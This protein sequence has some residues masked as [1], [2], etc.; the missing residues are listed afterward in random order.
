MF[1]VKIESHIPP[2]SSPKPTNEKIYPISDLQVGDSF[3][4]PPDM[5]N[6]ARAAVSQY[7][8][9]HRKQGWD[10]RTSSNPYNGC[11]IWRTA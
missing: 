5:A 7:K 10:Y 9:N 8:R 1:K 2:P 6:R 4:V 11:R 3:W